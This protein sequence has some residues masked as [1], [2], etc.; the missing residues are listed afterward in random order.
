MPVSQAYDRNLRALMHETGKS[1]GYGDL[2]KEG[3]YCNVGGP[4][5]ET[6]WE[7]QIMLKLGCD[8]VGEWKY[9]TVVYY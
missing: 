1:L 5:F 3:I 4:S 2:M 9:S 7:M 8:A 6:I